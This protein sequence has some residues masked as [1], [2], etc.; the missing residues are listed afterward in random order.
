[1]W[2]PL[3]LIY[4][5]LM[6]TR[7]AFCPCIFPS[8]NTYSIEYFLNNQWQQIYHLL[9]TY[10]MLQALTKLLL[11]NIFFNDHVGPFTSI[12]QMR[13][14]RPTEVKVLFIGHVS[15]KE[16]S[17]SAACLILKPVVFSHFISCDSLHQNTITFCNPLCLKWWRE[18][19]W[20]G[21]IK[22]PIAVSWYEEGVCIF[23]IQHITFSYLLQTL[24]V[25]TGIH[26]SKHGSAIY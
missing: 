7:I 1:M 19:G 8:S 15:S 11:C 2:R 24:N 25:R 13:K 16:R 10:F 3:V 9:S 26:E 14:L 4:I 12:L 21:S 6:R 17:S 20:E 22:F 23:L 18:I 5:S